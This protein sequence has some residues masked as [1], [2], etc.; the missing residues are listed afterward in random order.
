MKIVEVDLAG[1]KCLRTG[2]ASSAQMVIARIPTSPV[3]GHNNPTFCRNED[4]ALW[5]NSYCVIYQ[6]FPLLWPSTWR[7]SALGKHSLR[8]QFDGAVVEY[9]LEIVAFWQKKTF[10]HPRIDRQSLTQRVA[11]N[12]GKPYAKQD[13]RTTSKGTKML[14]FSCRCC[15]VSTKAAGFLPMASNRIPYPSIGASKR[16]SK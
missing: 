16:R 8:I 10:I 11:A 6:P 14:W 1:P 2:G 7:H 3:G 9:A 15:R 4:K 13:S 12:L 5:K